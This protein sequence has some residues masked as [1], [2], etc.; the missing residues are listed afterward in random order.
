MWG[1]AQRACGSRRWNT[2]GGRHASGT[3]PLLQD[4][5]GQGTK[6]MQGDGRVKKGF[7]SSMPTTGMQSVPSH[8]SNEAAIWETLIRPAV[9]VTCFFPKEVEATAGLVHGVVLLSV[10]K[11]TRC[12][13][14]PS[15]KLQSL[16]KGIW[17]GALLSE[18]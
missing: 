7:T 16:K 1:R 9:E 11:E 2:V 14:F 10:S 3:L 5:L 6:W 15:L 8:G 13:F 12:S 4:R 17:G 18:G